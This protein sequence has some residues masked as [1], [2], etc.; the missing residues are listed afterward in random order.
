MDSQ[1]AKSYSH[2]AGM[3]IMAQEEEALKPKE[4]VFMEKVE[5]EAP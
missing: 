4:D 5:K 1:Y 2:F 3:I